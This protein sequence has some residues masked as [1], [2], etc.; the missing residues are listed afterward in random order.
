MFSTHDYKP[1]VPSEKLDA[2]GAA[3]LTD[4]ELVTILIGSGG[5]SIPSGQ[6]ARSLL[7]K[8]GSLTALF[9]ADSQE[10]RKI[11]GVGGRRHVLFKAVHELA[12]RHQLEPLRR[13]HCMTDPSAV[14]RFL[15]L[16][17]KGRH[18]ETFTCIYL[19]T[20]HRVIAVDELFEGTIDGASVYPRE[21]VINALKNKAAAVIFAHNH[22]SG[23][24]EPS[25][26]D[27]R[28][29]QR[30]IAALKVVDIMVLDHMVVGD[31]HVVSFAERG[32]L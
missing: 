4:A 17:L 5:G 30:L 12:I 7:A 16:I 1:L 32:L 13:P 3:A 19:D 28:I 25:Q 20:Q 21:V 22:P 9:S 18:R 15:T 23:V 31:A 2:L 11:S 14:K 27:L 26:A 24:A 8:F 29:T 10:V 6:V